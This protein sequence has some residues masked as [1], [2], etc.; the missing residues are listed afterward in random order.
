MQTTLFLKVKDLLEFKLFYIVL[1]VS[2]S[3][4]P[5]KKNQSSFPPKQT[6][7]SIPKPSYTTWVLPQALV[8]PGDS[9]RRSR[10]NPA[11]PHPEKKVP[12]H[13]PAMSLFPSFL[14]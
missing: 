14:F 7:W 10:E 4:F 11:V 3:L 2:H 9:F 6:P 8:S 13:S 5:Q 12:P 1:P